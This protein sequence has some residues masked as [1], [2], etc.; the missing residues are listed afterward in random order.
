[1]EAAAWQGMVAPTPPAIQRS[2]VWRSF[3]QGK[4]K[5]LLGVMGRQKVFLLWPFALVALSKEPRL[6]SWRARS[7]GAVQEHHTLDGQSKMALEMKA[8]LKG[9]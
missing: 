4:E 9:G 1:M 2:W 8:G 6:G 3:Q 5:E 7:Q